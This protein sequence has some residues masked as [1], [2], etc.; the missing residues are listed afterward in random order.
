[1]KRFFYPL[2]TMFIFFG[3]IHASTDRTPDFN[4]KNYVYDDEGVPVFIKIYIKSPKTGSLDQNQDGVQQVLNRIGHEDER[5]SYIVVPIKRHK[6]EK[7]K[8]EDDADGYDESWWKCPYCGR[9]NDANSN[10]CGT[11]DC[12]LHR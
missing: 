10:Y 12:V 6:K 3:S 4:L 11:K 1:M 2:I 5:G 8:D 9:K 7:D